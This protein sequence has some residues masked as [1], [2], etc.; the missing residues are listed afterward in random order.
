MLDANSKVAL[1]LLTYFLALFCPAVHA[2]DAATFGW[3]SDYESA[4]AIAK[5]TNRP[6]MVVL[7][8]VP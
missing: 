6:L 3:H 8:C 5:K 1:L 2:D 4:L 7:R